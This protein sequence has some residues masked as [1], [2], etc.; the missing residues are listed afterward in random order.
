MGAVVLGVILLF[1]IRR[2]REAR[3]DWL[4]QLDL[5]GIWEQDGDQNSTSSHTLT[6]RGSYAAGSYT[7]MCD[8]QTKHGQWYIEQSSLVLVDESGQRESYG[9]RAFKKG[10]IGLDGP[11]LDKQIFY[12]HIENIVPLRR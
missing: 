4:M 1:W 8:Q 6:L 5:P 10:K 2:T 11:N 12:K 3:Q 9:L 7:M